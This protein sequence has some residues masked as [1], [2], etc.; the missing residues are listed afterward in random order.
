MADFAAAKY[1]EIILVE[2]LAD[3]QPNSRYVNLP[4]QIL[5]P[6]RSFEEQANDSMIQRINDK[7]QMASS[8]KLW[9]IAEQKHKQILEKRGYGCRKFP[10]NYAEESSR[11]NTEFWICFPSP[12]SKC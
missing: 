6:K 1:K 8:V 4:C 11:L 10:E 12:K 7:M 2:C 9:F 5:S 3:F